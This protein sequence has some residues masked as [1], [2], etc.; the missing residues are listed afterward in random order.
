MDNLSG[1]AVLAAAGLIILRG[2][3][4]GADAYSAFLRGAERGMKSALALLPALCA[5]T[6]MISLLSAS[7]LT[8]LLTGLLSPVTALLRLPP[9]T[10]P[11]LLLR[12]L[13]G[14][15]SLSVMQEIFAVAGPDSRAGRIASVLMGSSETI[16]YTMTVYLGAAGVRRLPDVIWISLAS[17]AV[18]AVVCGWLA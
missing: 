17:Y 13:S 14:S 1:L 15:G 9:E 12:P 6:L 4:C 10:T 16:V 7:G 11:M 5:M 2:L 8:R 3:V 18:G